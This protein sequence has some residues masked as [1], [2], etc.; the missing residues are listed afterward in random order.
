[1]L[2]QGEDRIQTIDQICAR[3]S[4]APK[5]LMDPSPT[6]EHLRMIVK[7]ACA[8]VDHGRLAPTRYVYIPGDMRDKL[9]DAFAEA[10]KEVD[11]VASPERVVMARERAVAGPCLIAVIASIDEDNEIIPMHEQWIAV[12]ASL[13]NFMLAVDALGYH[14]KMVS[15]NR[16]KS[17]ALRNCF[18]LC[19]N[20]HLV[21]FA[22]LGTSRQPP[23][24]RP[25][26]SFDEVLSAL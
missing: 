21:G 8:G 19:E 6:P 10:V 18:K 5:Y 26:K 14:G 4:V 1:M 2:D 9:A 17:M 12:G 25:R 11:P 20:E 23:K 24:E 3:R 16:V 7:A 22:V 13:Q 15:G